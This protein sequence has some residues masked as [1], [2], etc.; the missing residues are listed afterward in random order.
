MA[1]APSTSTAA[2]ASDA[3]SCAAAGTV[4]SRY[5]GCILQ[6]PVG[7]V[8]LDDHGAPIGTASWNVYQKIQLYKN[9][10]AIDQTMTVVP[11]KMDAALK[12]VTMEWTPSCSGP[13][14]GGTPQLAGVPTW[15]PGDQH[16]V[17]FG[18]G[19]WWTGTTGVGLID[20]AWKFKFS[21][22]SSPNTPE[23]DWSDSDLTV[24]CDV[25]MGNEAIPET[26]PGCVFPKYYPTLE[27]NSQKYPS[28]AALYW[29]LMQKLQTHPGSK[30]NNSPLT[31][32]ADDVI[33]AANRSK[34]CPSSWV[35][36]PNGTSDSPSCDE[37]PFAK[38]RQSG[39]QS[40]TGNQCAQ[41]YAVKDSSGWQLKYDTNYP[42]PTWNEVCGRGAIPLSQNTGAG[43][44]LGRFTTAMRLH[45]NDAYFVDTPG[46]ANCNQTL[47]SLP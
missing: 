22:P 20:L 47:C 13:C 26:K 25:I 38:S 10:N 44:Q 18:V 11:Q 14:S 17:S 40:V 27:I 33:A 30:A 39:G 8:L 1:A 7:V 21:S 32:Q 24:R 42:L 9:E 4:Y 15:T 23:I 16:A 5:V 2:I 37:Y 3:V 43:G 12:S 29:L 34:M 46:F 6:A 45:D 19:Q 31:R 28:A 36:P 35:G 41:F